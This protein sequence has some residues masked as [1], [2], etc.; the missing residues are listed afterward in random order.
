MR[1]LIITAVKL[2][3]IVICYLCFFSCSKSNSPNP[4]NENTGGDNNGSTTKK[5]LVTIKSINNTGGNGS[6]DHSNTLTGGLFSDG[7]GHVL[8]TFTGGNDEVSLVHG[9]NGVLTKMKG[10]WRATYISSNDTA[11]QVYFQI[12]HIETNGDTTK[13]RA[14]VVGTVD[15]LLYTV[16]DSMTGQQFAYLFKA[17]NEVVQKFQ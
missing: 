5:P 17:S 3:M 4:N 1:R 11:K 15:A 8:Q 9:A 7:A 12:V 6:F 16:P 10:A 2:V 14:Y 13:Y